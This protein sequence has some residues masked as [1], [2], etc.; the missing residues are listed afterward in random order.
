M[1]KNQISDESDLISHPV[2]PPHL[3]LAEHAHICGH[4]HRSSIGLGAA[5][6]IMFLVMTGCH[7]QAAPLAV[8]LY[9][10]KADD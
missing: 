1:E 5:R 9:T 7:Y 8:S 2:N 10:G 6:Y 4:M 3:S